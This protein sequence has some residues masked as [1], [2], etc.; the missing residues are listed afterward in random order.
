MME[1]D[2]NIHEWPAQKCDGIRSRSSAHTFLWMKKHWLLYVREE[3]CSEDAVSGVTWINTR[4]GKD[5]HPTCQMDW[6]HPSGY[7]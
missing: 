2:Y 3:G 1:R 6:V 4:P 7:R 5:E